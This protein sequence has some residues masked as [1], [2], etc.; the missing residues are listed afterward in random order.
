MSSFVVLPCLLFSLVLFQFAAS[1]SFNIDTDFDS[2]TK[3]TY[4][5]SEHTFGMSVDTNEDFNGDGFNDIIVSDPF[6]KKAYLVFGG[7][8]VPT[9]PSVVF[10]GPSGYRFPDMCK[11]AGDVNN[12]GYADL[13]FGTQGANAYLVF[14][15]ETTASTYA[16]TDAN[17]RTITYMPGTTD[18]N[19]FGQTLSAAGDVNKDGFDDFVI[20]DVVRKVGSVEGAGACYLI[21][22]GINL[23]SLSATALGSAG[24]T[25]SGTSTY[26]CF[27][28]AVAAAGD[29]NNDG[30][31]DIVISSTNSNR[32]VYLIY[33]GASLTSF[34]TSD[35][36]PGVVFPNPNTGDL[37]GSSLSSA[38]DFNGDKIDDLVIASLSYTTISTVFI[39]F[40]G[41]PLPATFNLIN[42]TSTTGVRYFTGKDDLGGMSVSGGVDINFDGMDDIIIGAPRTN[43][44]HG[45]AHV[46]F[47]SNS[48]VDSSVFQL[49]NGGISLNASLA[50]NKRFGK[51]V[52]LAEGVGGTNTRGTVVSALGMSRRSTMYYLH[53]FLPIPSPASPSV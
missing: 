33:G 28:G 36:F 24:I 6:L 9:S 47:G 4:P 29:I 39:V 31:A 30:F 43:N 20:C 1:S 17:P 52:I 26:Q 41:P 50:T 3:I 22:G 2:S 37:F 16:V 49:G 5:S 48:P 11:F 14:G 35:S 25:I 42:L 15:G 21:Y 12:D 45:A 40:G 27:G 38:G 23:E 46:V 44:G 10:K 32:K 51:V 19:G 7:N 34:K 53:D 8:I 13:L 18:Y